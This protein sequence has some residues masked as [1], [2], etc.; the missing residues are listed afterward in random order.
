MNF[1]RGESVVPVPNLLRPR[2]GLFR[3]NSWFN[4]QIACLSPLTTV[5]T[6]TQGGMCR[7]VGGADVRSAGR[8]ARPVWEGLFSLDAR[9]IRTWGAEFFCGQGQKG[10]MHD[11]GGAIKSF[12][13]DDVLMGHVSW[14]AFD[15]RYVMVRPRDVHLASIARRP[16]NYSEEM[17]VRDVHVT[18]LS[19]TYKSFLLVHGVRQ[20]IKVTQSDRSAAFCDTRGAHDALGVVGRP[21]NW[22]SHT[23]LQGE[24]LLDVP[25]GS[26]HALAADPEAAPAETD[27]AHDAALQRHFSSLALV[28]GAGCVGSSTALAPELE[29]WAA[30]IGR[31]RVHTY[32][33]AM[34][35]AALC[36]QQVLGATAAE[37]ATIRGEHA[38]QQLGNVKQDF[39]SHI[40]PQSY[41]TLD[42][43]SQLR[44]SLRRGVA[45]GHHYALA[46]PTDMLNTAPWWYKQRFLCVTSDWIAVAR[47][48][49]VVH[50]VGEGAYV[51]IVL[52]SAQGSYVVRA[53][54]GGVHERS[55]AVDADTLLSMEWVP[56]TT[57]DCVRFNHPVLI[58][59]VV[60]GAG[61]S[62]FAGFPSLALTKFVHVL[63][64]ADDE[65]QVKGPSL[66]A[67]FML[68][69]SSA[70]CVF[71][72]ELEDIVSL[73]IR[74][75]RVDPLSPGAHGHDTVVCLNLWGKYT[76]HPAW[77]L[78]QKADTS[79]V[80]FLQGDPCKVVA[81]RWAATKGIIGIYDGILPHARGMASTASRTLCRALEPYL[82]DSW[83]V[84]FW[85]PT[86]IPV[87]LPM[88]SYLQLTLDRD[89]L[90]APGVRLPWDKARKVVL[91]RD[92]SVSTEE[93]YD[94]WTETSESRSEFGDELAG[95]T[96]MAGG[97]ASL[98][99][100]R[101]AVPGSVSGVTSIGAGNTRRMSSQQFAHLNRDQPTWVKHVQGT[102]RAARDTYGCRIPRGLCSADIWFFRST[103]LRAAPSLKGD[104]FCMPRAFAAAFQL[105]T[106]ATDAQ[107]GAFLAA[108]K[109]GMKV[110]CDHD[111]LGAFV[112]S[113]QLGKIFEGLRLGDDTFP[114]VT[115]AEVGAPSKWTENPSQGWLASCRSGHP[116][117][118]AVVDGAGRSTHV[119]LLAKVT[120]SFSASD[121]TTM[122]PLTPLSS[123]RIQ[124]QAPRKKAKFHIWDPSPAVD[125]QE[126]LPIFC[127][128][129]LSL[130]DISHVKH[131]WPIR[132]ILDTDA[133]AG[134]KRKRGYG[135]KKTR[136]RE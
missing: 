14:D 34:R 6:R 8:M 68:P 89:G 51:H 4:L 9:G 120:S 5:D 122:L 124:V 134:T 91:S 69:L 45:T 37:K 113:R 115:V 15:A 123:V 88:K 7:L 90:F 85:G 101:Y 13:E 56:T 58:N 62:R 63:D 82:G 112:R 99:C 97:F 38:F 75:P 71:A 65:L 96:T 132:F 78:Y 76:D 17:V 42:C 36:V 100:V 20:G 30:A 103:F 66:H 39:V 53:A 79:L 95:I 94:A 61:A 44:M 119:C 70:G 86:P 52:K 31:A 2:H 77:G 84:Q 108:V 136:S 47:L 43:E 19:D 128:H 16:E 21:D 35:N 1:L 104:K 74:N 40:C 27:P 26:R 87:T 72:R 133:G 98:T 10:V 48:L 105:A 131:A 60:R 59:D 73:C 46:K 117:I 111:E 54:L 127:K 102:T 80:D 41:L 49:G 57:V 67:G 29:A 18:V 118:V 129:N 125:S 24:S 12:L 3:E 135:S 22:N 107:A 114:K 110:K 130:L 25:A 32:H 23:L 106:K 83:G 11:F 93:I 50:L 81:R 109:D 28:G 33:T 126:Y 92:V 116:E 121:C 64:D 55:A